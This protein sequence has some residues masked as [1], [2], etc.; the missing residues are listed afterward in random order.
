[1]KKRLIHIGAVLL[2]L[3]GPIQAQSAKW[4]KYRGAVLIER[5]SYDGDSFHLRT[6]RGV[7]IFRLYFVDAPEMDLEFADRVQ[8]QAD[9]WG[10]SV[11]DTLRLGRI[12]REFTRQF[13]QNGVT[14]WTRG[15]D[16]QGRSRLPRH[17]AIV[18][19]DDQDLA[20][21]L[22][23]NGLAR[24]YGRGTDFPDGLHGRDAWTALRAAETEAR[25]ARRGGWGMKKH[26]P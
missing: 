22:V 17:Y 6:H 8:E 7:R 18:R 19:A 15:E 23:R 21:E 5:Q 3:G 14:V 25:E 20:T 13:M 16:A 10:I 2:L 11:E 12:A 24:L 26:E 4:T 1:M 9:S